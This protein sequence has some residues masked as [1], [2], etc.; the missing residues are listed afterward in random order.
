MAE[1]IEGSVIKAS[2]LLSV[3]HRYIE[4]SVHFSMARMQVYAHDN[5]NNSI[6]LMKLRLCTHILYA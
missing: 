2:N 1:W 6:L 4:L 5:L 3:S